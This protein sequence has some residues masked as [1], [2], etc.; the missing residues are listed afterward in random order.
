MQKPYFSKVKNNKNLKTNHST[1][2][3]GDNCK[4]L[5]AVI[6]ITKNFGAGTRK[7]GYIRTIF[8]RNQSIKILSQS[9]N[10]FEV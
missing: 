6:N 9:V 8:E 5:L 10:I 4:A 2:G 7:S 1:R 3:Q